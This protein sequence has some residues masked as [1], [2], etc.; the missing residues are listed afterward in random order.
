MLFLQLT[1]TKCQLQILFGNQ[2]TKTACHHFL[3]QAV[4]MN[5]YNIVGGAVKEDAQLFQRDHRNIFSFFQGI[6]RFVVNPT[7][8]E[9]VLG[10]AL[11][12]HRVP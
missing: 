6:Q 5:L 7:F 3:R 9:L 12:L 2:G 8:Y 1:F 10:Y 4:L 11:L